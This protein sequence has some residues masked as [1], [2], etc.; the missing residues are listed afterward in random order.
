LFKNRK[1]NKTAA[2]LKGLKPWLPCKLW[3]PD[4]G[5]NKTRL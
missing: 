3:I 4:N 5:Q 1:L 2:S